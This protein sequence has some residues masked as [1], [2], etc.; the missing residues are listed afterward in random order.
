MFHNDLYDNWALDDYEKMDSVGASFEAIMDRLVQYLF[1][2]G[3]EH[4]CL[5]DQ[6]IK[7]I[8]CT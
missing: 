4:H 2:G 3:S 8:R 7:P 1:H 6:A 5:R